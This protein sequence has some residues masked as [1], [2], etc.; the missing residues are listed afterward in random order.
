MIRVT[1]LISIILVIGALALIGLRIISWEH[2]ISLITLA[3]GL[4]GGKYMSTIDKIIARRYMALAIA[5][6]FLK[7]VTLIKI[8]NGTIYLEVAPEF[9]NAKKVLDI[10]SYVNQV[11]PGFK[12][13]VVKGERARLV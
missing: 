9:Y 7:E 1:E 2:G 12:V 5:R 10:L 3:I 11:F 6:K 4:V 13:E 8:T